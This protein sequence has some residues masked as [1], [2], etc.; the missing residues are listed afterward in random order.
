[1]VWTSA[2]AYGCLLMYSIRGRDKT[3][4]SHDSPVIDLHTLE[5][6]R[7][8]KVVIQMFFIFIAFDFDEI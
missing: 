5:S 1:M 6:F 8:G 2:E 3:T 4:D 7:N